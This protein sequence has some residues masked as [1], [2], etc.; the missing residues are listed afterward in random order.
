MIYIMF[1]YMNVRLCA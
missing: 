1:M